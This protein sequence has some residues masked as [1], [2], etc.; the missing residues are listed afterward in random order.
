[1]FFDFLDGVLIVCPGFAHGPYII[2]WC[3]FILVIQT[4][5][6]IVFEVNLTG[7]KRQG[8][9]HCLLSPEV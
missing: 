8:F 4:L 2:G 3:E 6:P 9:P 5:K 7:K 1:M